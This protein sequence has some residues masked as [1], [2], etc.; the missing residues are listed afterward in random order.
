M[1]TTKTSD[2]VLRVR[3]YSWERVY[4][5]GILCWKLSWVQLN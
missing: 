4:G 2:D 3:K 5:N 1:A